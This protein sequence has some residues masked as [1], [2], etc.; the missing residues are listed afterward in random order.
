MLTAGYAV[1]LQFSPDAFIAI[2]LPAVVENLLDQF[3]VFC[4]GH[5]PLTG[6]VIA[7]VVISTARDFQYV[8]H[9]LHFEFF[10]MRLNKLKSH[11]FGLLKMAI[12]FFR[13]SRSWRSRLFSRSSWRIRAAA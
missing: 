10:P 1:I 12:A 13:I 9:Y 7:P 6:G 4:V 2:R 11:C 8:T 3:Y 5:L